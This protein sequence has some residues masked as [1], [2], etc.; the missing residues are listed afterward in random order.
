MFIAGT[1]DL[2]YPEFLAVNSY[3]NVSI[4]NGY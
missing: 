2:R 4:M 3:L 1:V